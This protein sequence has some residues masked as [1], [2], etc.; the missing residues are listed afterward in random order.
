MYASACHLLGGV[1][2]D[3]APPFIVEALDLPG[4]PHKPVRDALVVATI[5]AVETPGDV[6]GVDGLDGSATAD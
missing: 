3:D 4:D 1:Q 6:C 5:V 2:L